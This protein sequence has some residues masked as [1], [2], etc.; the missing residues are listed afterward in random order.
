[1]SSSN[2]MRKCTFLAAPPKLYLCNHVSEIFSGAIA[3]VNND[4]AAKA[5]Y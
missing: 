4:L 5:L 3:H 2:K 1:M